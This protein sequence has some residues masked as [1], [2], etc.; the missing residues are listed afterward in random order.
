MMG[1]IFIIF[2]ISQFSVI[3][4]QKAGAFQCLEIFFDTFF[5]DIFSSQR[6]KGLLLYPSFS[7]FSE[8]GLFNKVAQSSVMETFNKILFYFLKSKLSFMLPHPQLTNFVKIYPS[9]IFKSF[10][11][12]LLLFKHQQNFCSKS[13]KIYVLFQKI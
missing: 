2:L 5:F 8:S 11:M 4:I 7:S 13:V 1:Y 10:F 3:K 6:K 9:F 12:F